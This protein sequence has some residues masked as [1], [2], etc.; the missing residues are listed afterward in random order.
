MLLHGATKLSLSVNLGSPWDDNRQNTDCRDCPATPGFIKD[1]FYRIYR[2]ISTAAP[3]STRRSRIGSLMWMLWPHA[4]WQVNVCIS[5]L[6]NMSHE[7]SL[8][9]IVFVWGW[10]MLPLFGRKSKGFWP[11]FRN[12]KNLSLFGSPKGSGCNTADFLPQ[13]GQYNTQIK[14]RRIPLCPLWTTPLPLTL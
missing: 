9:L 6:Y 5:L 7:D 11:V 3:C 2:V 8:D 4:F 1:Q 13:M 10:Q 12:R 14:S